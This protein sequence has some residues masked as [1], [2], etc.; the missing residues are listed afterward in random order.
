[1]LFIN[2]SVN[3]DIQMPDWDQKIIR[4]ELAN[5]FKY[6]AYH[7]KDKSE[8]FNLRLI[9]HAGSID[10]PKVKGIAHAVEHMVFNQT[11][12]HPDG[13]HQY[14]RD[15]GWQT[16]KQVNARTQPTETQ[17]M[18]RTRPN[19]ALNLD[20]SLQLLAEIASNAT[21]TDAQWQKEQKIKGKTEQAICVT[22]RVYMYRCGTRTHQGIQVKN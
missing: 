10:E 21:F 15:L 1:M 11:K 2:L 14:I 20:G 7:S 4:G 16:G 17:Y 12:H 13:L 3:A 6:Y 19:D 22:L 9:V 8:P 18:I 5:G